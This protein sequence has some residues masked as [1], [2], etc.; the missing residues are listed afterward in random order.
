MSLPHTHAPSGAAPARQIHIT[1]HGV[2]FRYTAACDQGRVIYTVANDEPAPY[3]HTPVSHPTHFFFS[4][5]ILDLSPR[6]ASPL[7]VE[8]KATFQYK[9]I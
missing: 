5:F 9:I 1:R 7:D 4:K 3:T 8:I 6:L 2:A